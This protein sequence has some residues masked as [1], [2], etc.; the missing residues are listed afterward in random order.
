MDEAAV[1][2]DRPKRMIRTPAKYAENDDITAVPRQKRKAN[3][4]QSEDAAAAIHVDT[5]DYILTDPKSPL[6]T[7]D[8]TVS[9]SSHLGVFV[10]LATMVF[11]MF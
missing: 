11:R 6:T 7:I 4:E 10:N 9:S 8:I 1:N 3:Q 2:R 5:L